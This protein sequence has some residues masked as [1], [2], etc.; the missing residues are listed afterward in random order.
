M[1][2][3][4]EVDG[5]VFEV[6][7]MPTDDGAAGDHASV[8][9]A[10]ARRTSAPGAVQ[11]GAAGLVVS[12]RASIGDIL[13]EGDVVATIEAMKMIRELTTPHGG[14]VREIHASEG[15]LVAAEDVL[16]VVS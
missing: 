7:V 15:D 9:P 13:G 5:E 10:T 4:V 16:M 11:C 14:V 1:A 6:K 8:Q 2:F 3:S 12:I